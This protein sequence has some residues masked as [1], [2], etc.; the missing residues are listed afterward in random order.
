LIAG[1]YRPDVALASGGMGVVWRGWDERLERVVAIKQIR[2]QPG[3]SSAETNAARDR[4]MREARI[5]ARLHHPGAVPIYDVVEH[6]GRN[7]DG[8]T[9]R[10]GEEEGSGADRGAAAGGRAGPDGP[11]AGPV[12]DGARRGC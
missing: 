5:T 8:D 6:D 7:D 12:F 9:E 3:L 10:C 1:R 2:L 11:G 4:A